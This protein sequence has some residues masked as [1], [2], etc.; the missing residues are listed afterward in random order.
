M[1]RECL[2]NW[3]IT[4]TSRKSAISELL[5]AFSFRET[6]ENLLLTA[7]DTR[8]MAGATVVH[9]GI[10]MPHCR[11]I[12]VDDFMIVIGRSEKGIPWPEEKV[13]MVILFL[14]PVHPSGP[15]EHMMLIRQLANSLRGDGA[16]DLLESKTPEEAASLLGLKLAEG[17]IDE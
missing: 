4:S 2:C 5:K 12:L 6:T 1:K 15:H 13:R 8:E 14:T 10:A 11:S 7:L 17:G 9:K 16:K 3:N